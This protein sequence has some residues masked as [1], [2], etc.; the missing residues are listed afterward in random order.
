MSTNPAAIRYH[1][2]NCLTSLLGQRLSLH[3]RDLP[4]EDKRS[5]NQFVVA[6]SIAQQRSPDGTPARPISNLVYTGK[7]SWL[8]TVIFMHR[9]KCQKCTGDSGET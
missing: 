2:S 1:F 8:F 4:A 3:R 7:H 5:L 9:L 6:P